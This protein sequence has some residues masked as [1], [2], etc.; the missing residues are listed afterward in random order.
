MGADEADG[1]LNSLW[2]FI[3]Y[4]GLYKNADI[5]VSYAVDFFFILVS[6]LALAFRLWIG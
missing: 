1:I 4:E 6:G 3:M 5:T 2:L